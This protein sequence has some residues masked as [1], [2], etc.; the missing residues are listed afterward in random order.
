MGSSTK[1]RPGCAAL[2]VMPGPAQRG[3]GEGSA[4][5]SAAAYVDVLDLPAPWRRQGL[6]DLAQAGK[7]LVAVGQRG[8]ILLPDDDG[9][10]GGRPGCR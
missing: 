5:A 4:G 10:T 3:L 1:L 9:R 6:L 2:C 8:H 7:R